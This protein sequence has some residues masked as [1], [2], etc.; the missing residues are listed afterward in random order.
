MKNR[1]RLKG[2]PLVFFKGTKIFFQKVFDILQ[3]SGC[4]KNTK[5]PLLDF[6]HNEIVQIS[7]FH[8]ELG[9]LNSYQQKSLFASNP[10]FFAFFLG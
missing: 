9:F 4:S 7:I 2:P 3:Q 8:L 1:M 6:W 5:G 10:N